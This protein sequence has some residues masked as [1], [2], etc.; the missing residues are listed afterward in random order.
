MVEVLV[1]EVLLV[2][3]LL[4][5]L[6][7]LELLDVEEVDVE[8]VDDVVLVVDEVL[9]VLLVDEVLVDEVLLVEVLVL[10][11][12]DVVARIISKNISFVTSHSSTDLRTS[13]CCTCCCRGTCSR[14]LNI[15]PR[16]TY[17]KLRH[18]IFTCSCRCCRCYL[19][20][21]SE[22]FHRFFFFTYL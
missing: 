6:E 19:K 3:V 4:V 1:L 22:K 16:N 10:E 21:K 12:V 5:E 9:D 7:L 14:S 11:V 20:I 17:E 2:E 8:E 18:K 13:R 15:E